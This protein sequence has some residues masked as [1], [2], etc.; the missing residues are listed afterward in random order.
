VVIGNPNQRP[1]SD[2]LRPWINATDVVRHDSD[3][4]VIDFTGLSEN[5]AALYEGPFEF[6]RQNVR[7]ARANDRNAKTREQWWLYE[8]PRIEMRKA[9]ANLS[10]FIV[11]PVVAKHRIFAWRRAPT[12]SMNLL[13][14]TARA[15]DTTFG[16]LHS[17]FHELWS[18]RMGTSLEDR[19]R[20]TPT[21]L[22]D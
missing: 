13:D 20:N 12:L 22:L 3:T 18:L 1:N 8:R 5:E 2:V 4:W 19:P 10:R 14:V 15:D 6:A 11:T 9:T 21:S 17:R 7:P 16:I